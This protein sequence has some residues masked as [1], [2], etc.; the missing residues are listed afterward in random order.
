MET[1]PPGEITP[2]LTSSSPDPPPSFSRRTGLTILSIATSLFSFLFTITTSIWIKCSPNGPGLDWAT[3]ECA[4]FVFNLSILSAISLALNIA[5]HRKEPSGL[6]ALF[7]FV[8]DALVG[9]WCAAFATRGFQELGFRPACPS[10]VGA[11]SIEQCRSAVVDVL[12]RVGFAFG[13]MLGIVHALFVLR[14]LVSAVR[15]IRQ[16]SST[17]RFPTG[18]ITVEFTIKVLRQEERMN[19]EREPHVPQP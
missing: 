16:D 5:R 2:L 12:L 11:N 10:G 4:N 14:A 1:S 6:Y 8:V 17:W 7:A 3:G 15:K 18:Q 9:M 13:I 19:S